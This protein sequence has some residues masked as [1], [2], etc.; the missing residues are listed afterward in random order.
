[1]V[2]D[3]KEEAT[4]CFRAGSCLVSALSFL[5]LV[6]YV[7]VVCLGQ[8]ENVPRRAFASCILSPLSVCFPGVAGVHASPLRERLCWCF[9]PSGD[10]HHPSPPFFCFPQESTISQFFREAGGS[11]VGGMSIYPVRPHPPWGLPTGT[12]SLPSPSHSSDEFVVL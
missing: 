10:S 11:F 9:L 3:S 2:A 12:T 1:M 8:E 7:L 5:A 6:P 4:P